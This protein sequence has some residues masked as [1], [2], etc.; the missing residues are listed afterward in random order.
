M[1]DYDMIFVEV[2]YCNN[3]QDEEGVLPVATQEGVAYVTQKHIF[4]RGVHFLIWRNGH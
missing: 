4:A 3:A 1:I 2:Y